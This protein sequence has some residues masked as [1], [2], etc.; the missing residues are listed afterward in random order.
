MQRIRPTELF[1]TEEWTHLRRR[2]DVIG[3]GMVV[4]AWGMIAG[5]MALAIWQPV[6]IPFAIMIIGARQLGL[7]ILMHEAAHGGLHKNKKVN[8]FLGQWLCGAPTGAQLS[9]Y[10]PYHLTHHKFTQQPEDPD[11]VLSAPFPVT[12]ASLKRKV[13][14]DLTGQTF[15]KQRLNQFANALGIGIRETQG[16]ENRMQGARDAVVPFIAFNFSLAVGLMLIGY[17]WAFFVLWL[18]PMA[19]WFPLVTRLRNIAEHALTSGDDVYQQ[20]RTTRA[21]LLER[22][23]IAPYWVNYHL[24]HHLFMHLPCYRL[25]EA[26]RLLQAKGITEKMEIQ[27][28][29]RAVLDLASSKPAS[30]PA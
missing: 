6:L 21:N 15:Y 1:S 19:T 2:S 23:L 3:V 10:R 14:R 18:V 17:W 27:P 13:I 8:D 5:T 22:L 7:A 16:A 12:K 20:A 4:H 11:L 26:H 25:A 29:Y 9:S 28:S 30:V 24:E